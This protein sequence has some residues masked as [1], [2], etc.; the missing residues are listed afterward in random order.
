MY[1]IGQW[2]FELVPDF[3][4]VVFAT[5]ISYV[6]PFKYFLLAEQFRSLLKIFLICGALHEHNG[7][8]RRLDCFSYVI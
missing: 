6:N 1:D 4:Q 3:S 5:T 8:L 2:R 7:P